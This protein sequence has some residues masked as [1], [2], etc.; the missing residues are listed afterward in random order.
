MWPG[1]RWV[2][3]EWLHYFR[4]SGPGD[5]LVKAPILVGGIAVPLLVWRTGRALRAAW[6]SGWSLWKR[7]PRFRF[8]YGFREAAIWA[9]AICLGLIAGYQTAPHA[10]WTEELWQRWK[11]FYRLPDAAATYT[12]MSAGIYVLVAW[13]SLWA[14]DS[15]RSLR[16]RVPVWSVLA[17]VPALGCEFWLHR[18]AARI[19]A[20]SV[21][22]IWSQASAE[23]LTSVVAASMIAGSLLLVRLYTGFQQVR[24]ARRP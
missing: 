6:Q 9:T 20:D 21:D 18:I 23:T 15:Q 3:V 24:N 8:Q 4:L 1:V 12:V 7:W 10:G 14:V 22:H 16:W 19:P 11:Q 5:W 2:E 13:G 17:V